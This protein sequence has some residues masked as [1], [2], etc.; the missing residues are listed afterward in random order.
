MPAVARSRFVDLAP[1]GPP[2]EITERDIAILKLFLEFPYLSVPYIGELLRYP[3]RPTLCGGKTVVRYPYL[4]KRLTRL[5]KD[6]GYLKCPSESWRAANSRY[7]PAVYTLAP[8]GKALLRQHGMHE[9]PPALGKDFAHAFGASLVMASLR[10]GIVQRPFLRLITHREILDHPACPDGTR[11]SADPF[12]IPVRFQYR[13][14][15]G[16]ALLADTHKEHDWTPFGVAHAA[17]DGRERKIF[18]P[19]IEFDRRTEPLESDRVD[20][21]SITRHLLAILALLDEGYHRHFGLPSVYVPIVT[22]GDA[23]KHS[24]QRLLLKLTGGQGSERILLKSTNDFTSWDAPP[25]ATDRMLV[26]PWDRA[27]YPPFDVLNALGAGY[28]DVSDP[29]SPSGP[30]LSAPGVVASEG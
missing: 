23:R 28:A 2:L 3:P 4:R 17:G 6:G 5:R 29:R 30:P 10:I 9:N 12:S 18:F 21:A 13:G 22:I 24:I 19:G 20:R 1:C 25:P 11:H 14:R 26:A 7:R 16:S 15:S 8:K 27:G